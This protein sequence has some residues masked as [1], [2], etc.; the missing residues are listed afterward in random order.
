MKVVFHCFIGFSV[1]FCVDNDAK[2]SH[3]CQSLSFSGFAQ[4]P[5]FCCAGN[6]SHKCAISRVDL[7]QD[8]AFDRQFLSCRRHNFQCMILFCMHRI[9]QKTEVKV[10]AFATNY[11]FL[12]FCAFSTKIALSESLFHKE[13][14]DM[15]FV[16]NSE[17]FA[18]ARTPK[19][20]DPCHPFSAS[21][22]I[23]QI[24]GMGCQSQNDVQSLTQERS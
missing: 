11:V 14:F 8:W 9:E 3:L 18:C 24:V 1:S 5:C 4:L 10:I 20:S 19:N 12:C 23:T 21:G 6:L 7:K 17:N 13:F 22:T 15:Q 16:G 2:K